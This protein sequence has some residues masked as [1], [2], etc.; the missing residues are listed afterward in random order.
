[1]LTLL[2]IQRRVA[3]AVLQGGALPDGVVV[4]MPG[5]IAIHQRHVRASLTKVLRATY[6]VVDRLVGEGF[7]AFAAD[8]FIRARPPST[9]CLAEYGGGFAVFLGEFDAS[10]HL[11]YLPDVA[12]MEWLIHESML[13]P[14]FRPI[15]AHAL[16]TLDARHIGAM[17]LSLDPSLRHFASVWPI[18]RIFSANQVG[19]DGHVDL[20]GGAAR[21]E[22]R[23]VGD[24][25]GIRALDAASHAFRSRIREGQ[26]LVDA[27]GCALSIDPEFNLAAAIASLI[28]EGL[29]AGVESGADELEMR[30]I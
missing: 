3:E 13:A 18:D 10:R 25:I 5:R 11:A 2:D 9:P 27:A 8:A 28:D 23:R 21:I 24:G 4:P 19:G 15:P 20:D 17:R 26:Q 6:P 29:L 22:I 1:M 7:F 16:A 12:H 14:A 30:P